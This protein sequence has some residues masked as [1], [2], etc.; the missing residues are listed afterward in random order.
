MSL[1]IIVATILGFTIS[2]YP[3][4]IFNF[5]S[6][7]TYPEP[8]GVSSSLCVLTSQVLTAI[9]TFTVSSLISNYGVVAAN[10]YYSS[11]LIFAMVLVTFVRSDLRRER[12]ENETTSIIDH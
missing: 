10:F 3:T 8:E 7:L 9:A 12:V 6:E 5:A 4:I 2:A 11:M 1:V